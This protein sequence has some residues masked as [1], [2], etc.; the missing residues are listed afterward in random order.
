MVR[1]VKKFDYS[2][3]I[4]HEEVSPTDLF[5]D[6]THEA[7][8]E[9]L[10]KLIENSDKGIT[11]GLEG[12]WGSGKSTVI[13]F[14]K[15]KVQK[16]NSKTIF[17]LFDAWAHE[18][19]P[20]RRIFLE[21]LIK[22][23]NPKGTD[24]YLNKLLPEIT[25]RKKTVIVNTDKKTSNLANFLSISAL[26]VPLGAA[27]LSAINYDHIYFPWAHG[28]SPN[29]AFI[30]GLIFCLAPF[31]V[32]G[33]WAKWGERD[34][35]TKKIKWHLIHSDSTEN[36]TQDITEDGERTSIEFERFFQKIIQHSVGN[37]PNQKFDRCIIVVDN[38]DRVDSKHFINIWST[39]QTFFQYRS[40]QGSSSADWMK[41]L[42]FIVPYDRDGLTQTWESSTPENSYDSLA[43]SFLNKCFQVRAEVPEPVMSAWC[44]FCIT[45]T[46]RALINWPTDE[47]EIIV[48]TF[49]RY[50]SRL[51]SSPTPRQIHNFVN[52]VGLL[53]MRWGGIMSAEAI[54]LYAIFRQKFSYKELRQQLL[55][56]GM[57][58][59]FDSTGDQ[60]T[61]KME[62][63]GMLFGV[64]KEK[65]VQL[66][67][68][69]EIRSTL[70]NGD[71]KSLKELIDAHGSAFWVAW[72]AIK[73]EILPSDTHSEE[74]RISSTKA[75]YFGMDES[76]KRISQEIKVF[77]KVWKS[78]VD[79]WD[80][81]RADYTESLS[82]MKN[83]VA[84]SGDFIDWLNQTIQRKLV[85]LIN[86]VSTIDSKVL[87][88]FEAQ[89]NLLTKFG[90]PIP[91]LT[92]PSLNKQNWIAWLDLL[93]TAKVSITQILPASGVIRELGSDITLEGNTI[94]EALLEQL[95]KTYKVFPSSKEWDS[96]TESLVAWGIRPQKE[97]SNNEA[98][99][100]MLKLSNR[101]ES[102][103]SIKECLSGTA[104]WVRGVSEDLEV[105]DSL[106]ILIGSVLLDSLQ[107]N[108][109]VSDELKEYWQNGDATEEVMSSAFEYLSEYGDLY[110]LWFIAK[111][112]LNKFATSLIESNLDKRNL[113]IYSSGV[114]NLE[115]YKWSEDTIEKKVI[116][117]LSEFGGLEQATTKLNADP[118]EYANVL[119]RLQKS[120][121]IKAVK[122]VK[123]VIENLS[124]DN[125][126]KSFDDDSWTLN[127]LSD[128][129]V[130]LDHRYKDAFERYFSKSLQKNIP[131]E[132]ICE[133]FD[134]L[135]GKCIDKNL[136]IKNLAENY[137]ESDDDGLSDKGFKSV[138]KELSAFVKDLDQAQVM[139]RLCVWLDKKLWDRIEWLIESGFRVKG[140]P[141]ESLSSRTLTALTQPNSPEISGA[142]DRLMKICKVSNPS[143]K[144]PVK[145]RKPRIKK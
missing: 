39:L 138:S 66:L 103:P 143:A 33:I 30:F 65:G 128:N 18:G 97:L 114:L 139:S 90:K 4:L 125:W 118:L 2:F 34:Q 111:D 21:S 134:L 19:D 43:Q 78:S 68:A 95:L 126:T 81:R 8:T 62:L 51:D 123:E 44:G 17:F 59:N 56:Q 99:K 135:L 55:E 12:G 32:L 87:K 110:A 70:T 82:L 115:S 127:C 94:E 48:N 47:K 28:T 98:Y 84:N 132:W 100:L 91:R 24:P 23:L 20:L 131:S 13:E 137:F 79:R 10:F 145:V 116:K 124:A 105:V 88:Q 38:L 80:Y 96:V 11:I 42:W 61:I 9:T 140:K 75:I 122:I 109:N 73:K 121:D 133:N 86:D 67:L 46:N 5:P 136:V 60:Q 49:Q 89:V 45:A 50:R 58:G 106:P 112:Q 6:K 16:S 53:G 57:P 36:Y 129:S 119:W 74:Y 25:G 69:P 31:F 107:K 52:Q 22:A 85:V 3:K 77:E 63:A 27:L 35:T 29:F 83:M 130:K 14:L 26:L 108:A 76:R 72:D 37:D 113:Y 144:M 117:S 93:E 101:A 1:T 120:G 92:Y 15:E 40:S 7:V 41:R 104:F 102:K 142:L 141:L 54:A 64:V 71:G